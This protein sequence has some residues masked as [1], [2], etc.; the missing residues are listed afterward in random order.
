MISEGDELFPPLPKRPRTKGVN[1]VRGGGGGVISTDNKKSCSLTLIF[2]LHTRGQ[3][4]SQKTQTTALL[5]E[6]LFFI[7][8]PFLLGAAFVGRGGI[9]NDYFLSV[10]MHD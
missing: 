10:L 5:K 7:D 9:T 1:S 8:F 3:K 2:V 6:G 4:F